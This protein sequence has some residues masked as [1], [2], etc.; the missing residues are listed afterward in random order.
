MQ[1]CGP[2][3][4]ERKRTFRRPTLVRADLFLGDKADTSAAYRTR[5][6]QAPR[7]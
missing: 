7:E 6:E 5:N 1:A 2:R 4:S 3:Q